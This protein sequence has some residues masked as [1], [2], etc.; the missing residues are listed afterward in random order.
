M[1]M[2][3]LLLSLDVAM[4]YLEREFSFELREILAA[5]EELTT[6]YPLEI[7]A[8]EFLS[9]F[10]FLCTTFYRNP[11]PL[12]AQFNEAALGVQHRLIGTKNSDSTVENPDSWTV[13]QIRCRF[14]S[15]PHMGSV[16]HQIPRWCDFGWFIIFPCRVT[17][18]KP[19][20]VL[21][22]KKDFRCRKCGHEF[23]LEADYEMGYSYSLPECCPNREDGCL[24]NGGFVDLSSERRRDR[25]YRDYQEVRVQEKVETL[26]L[27]RMPQSIWITLED[28]LVDCLKPGDSIDVNGIVRRRWKRLKLGKLPKATLVIQT[29][30]LVVHNK[31]KVKL[32][33]E[34]RKEFQDFWLNHADCVLSGRNQILQG[35]CPQ[36]FGLYLAKLALF[37][38]MAGGVSSATSDSGTSSRGES[39]VLLVGD[40]GTAKSQF[41]KYVSKL[42]PRSVLT[43]GVGSTSAG[44]TVAAV[45]S[46]GSHWHLEP[47]ALVLADGGVCCIDEFCSIPERDRGSI[48]EAMEQQTI[49]VAKAGMVSTLRS[50]CSIVAA[51]NPKKGNPEVFEVGLASPLL[52]RF[53]LVL[54]IKD[55]RSSEWDELLSSWLLKEA[56]QEDNS[57]GL[58]KGLSSE[59]SFERLQAYLCWVKEVFK[60]VMSSTAKEVLQRYYVVLRK[61]ESRLRV[62]IRVLE[63][64]VRLSQAHARLVARQQVTVQDALVAIVLMECSNPCLLDDIAMLHT[65]FPRDAEVEYRTQ[66]HVILSRL[67]LRH[68]LEHDEG[69]NEDD[70]MMTLTQ[71]AFVATRNGPVEKGRAEQRNGPVEKGRA[72]QRNGPVEKGRAEQRK[73]PVE[74]GRAEQRK[75]PGR[76]EQRK[77][78]VEKGRAEQRNGP[79]EKGRAEQRKGLVEKGRAEQ[80]KGPVEKGRAEQRDLQELIGQKRPLPLLGREEVKVGAVSPPS[81]KRSKTVDGVQESDPGTLPSSPGVAS[82]PTGDVPLPGRRTDGLEEVG[83]ISKI[84]E[85]ERA[86]ALF[87]DEAKNEAKPSE[88]SDLVLPKEAGNSSAHLAKSSA[89]NKKKTVQSLKKTSKTKE[90]ETDEWERAFALFSDGDEVTSSKPPSLFKQWNYKRVSPTLTPASALKPSPHSVLTKNSADEGSSVINEW[91]V[92]KTKSNNRLEEFSYQDPLSQQPCPTAEVGIAQ[93]PPTQESSVD[94]GTSRGGIQPGH[95]TRVVNS[96]RRIDASQKWAGLRADLDDFDLFFQDELEL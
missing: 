61:T 33:E 92:G 17:R 75:G 67:E 85:W 89:M 39:H 47:G 23:T 55:Q 5:S 35:F 50:R 1:K 15:L 72:E 57:L 94:C 70:Q 69:S 82:V 22:W 24:S 76:A 45:R 37:V 53:D 6:C 96:Q 59:W 30:Y 32:T 90:S 74:K 86:C 83:L 87:D 79:V 42:S 26:A 9:D 46:G 19:R 48:H 78:P 64:L 4:D 16:R 43:T 2:S 84:K 51:T 18:V 80:R 60:P 3:D 21:E 56:R 54:P 73:G 66:A 20:K 13:K 68:L 93:H 40:P 34:L 7:D 88:K 91:H 49:S 8:S 10:Q 52:S 41:L 63:S 25:C 27:G 11:L 31:P 38:V 81:P 44:L 65:T 62:T 77:G 29:N 95:E 58:G 28:D 36:I 12:L 71:H 14:K